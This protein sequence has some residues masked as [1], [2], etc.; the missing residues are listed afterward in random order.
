MRFL[1]TTFEGGG[2]VPPALCV[3]AALQARGHQVL[4]VSDEAN[5]A[6]ALSTGLSFKAWSSAPNRQVLGDPAD[7]LRDW[8]PRLPTSIVRAVC[9]GVITGPALAYARDTAAVINEFLPDVVVSNELL[10]GAV[11]AAEARGVP[12]ALLTANVW[13]YP[14]RDD[15]PPF[16]P[17][18]P[19]A[20][21]I[22][23]RRREAAIRN[24]IGKWYDAGL[25]DL[26]TAR[27]AFGLPPL[28]LCLS[29]LEACDRILLGVSAAFDYGAA[30]TPAPF[31]YVG[32][33][34]QT[35]TW[36]R[37]AADDIAL[38]DPSR[39][40]VLVS[41]STTHQD[42][43][44]TLKRTI[45]ALSGLNVN[46]VVT[47]GPAFTDLALPRTPNVKIVQQADHDIL[48]PHCELVVCHGGHGTVLRPLMHGKPV[49][50]IPSGRD[51]PENA[52]RLVG[53][54]A[55]L[56]LPR[57][58]STR[59][60][61]SAIQSILNNPAYTDAARRL[62]AALGRDPVGPQAAVAALEDLVISA[63]AKRGAPQVRQA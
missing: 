4:F 33:L 62:A 53:A 35:P 8:K 28:T 60:I 32:P 44:T 54:G 17:G 47:L 61:R 5:R 40:N 10:F 26:N 20:L 49:V 24:M 39:P 50:C 43:A 7:P 52:Q 14:T 63:A 34:G 3:A 57:R 22:F 9:K 2:H 18:L 19:P 15:I 38:I 31:V 6:A 25:A 30:N 16:G 55:G 56:R 29:Q 13:C 21:T 48:V 1:F 59:R 11:I 45:Q 27:T 51:Q 41:F 42:Q 37:N 36:A 12:I 23:E 58:A 46:G